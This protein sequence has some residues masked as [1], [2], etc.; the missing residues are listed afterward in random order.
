[1]Y[2][3]MH[4]SIVRPVD[5]T[6][7]PNHNTYVRRQIVSDHENSTM[8]SEILTDLEIAIASNGT[9]T[10]NSDLSTNICVESLWFPSYRW[11]I[12]YIVEYQLFFIYY[13]N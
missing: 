9:P 6:L 7:V 11:I 1:M 4:L 8:H 13:S 2:L 10:K 5:I 12:Q 3:Y